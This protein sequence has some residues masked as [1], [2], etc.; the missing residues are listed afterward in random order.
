MFAAPSREAHAG[1]MDRVYRPQR[2]LYDLTR[3]YYLLGRDRLIAGLALE[4]DS[5][6]IEVGCGTGRNLIAIARMYPEARLYGLDASEAMLQTARSKVGRAGLE[7]RILLRHGLAE[8]LSPRSFGVETFDH[9]LFSYSLS[10]VP[11][12]H[13]ALEAGATALPASGR[14]HV[15]DFADFKGLGLVGRR[16]LTAWLRAFHVT[17]RVEFLAALERVNGASGELNLLGRRYAFTFRS[18]PKVNWET[19][20]ASLW[21]G[22]HSFLIK[23]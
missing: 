22:D 10:M 20:P 1:L 7:H 6:L 2:H 17:P 14:C 12:W 9:V 3:K 5:T 19:S 13:A 15:V 8:R 21:R 18:A 4:P 16:A 11:D 23:P